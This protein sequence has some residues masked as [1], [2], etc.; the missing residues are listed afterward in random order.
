LDA[1]PGILSK[2]EVGLEVEL[3]TGN[4]VGVSKGS[5]KGHAL[6]KEDSKDAE[7]DESESKDGVETLPPSR[8]I[9][10]SR[11]ALNLYPPNLAA[12]LRQTGMLDYEDDPYLSRNI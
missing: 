7:E 10:S 3:P 5:R 6:S 11:A 12:Y 8:N 1:G 9:E 4:K 2:G